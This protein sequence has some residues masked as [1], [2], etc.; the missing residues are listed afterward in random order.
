MDIGKELVPMLP[1]IGGKARTKREKI[2]EEKKE[3]AVALLEAGRTYREIAE[4]LDI[5]IASVHRIA[6]EPYEKTLP[7]VEA[8]KARFAAKHYLL[9]DYILNG[10]E[11]YNICNASLKDRIICAAILADKGMQIEQARLHHKTGPLAETEAVEARA[12]ITGDAG[13]LQVPQTAGRMKQ[14]EQMEQKI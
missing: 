8:I 2:R 11:D 6:K 12:E 3:L 13:I 1:I 5:G 14:M 7:L 4:A 10:I 9:A